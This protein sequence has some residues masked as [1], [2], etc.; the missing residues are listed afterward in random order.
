[1]QY[2]RLEFVLYAAIADAPAACAPYSGIE[3]GRVPSP[4]GVRAP[5]LTSRAILLMPMARPSLC[6]P[7][8]PENARGFIYCS[9]RIILSGLSSLFRSTWPYLGAGLSG[10]GLLYELC[11]CRWADVPASCAT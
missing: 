2:V 8:C 4:M 1:M 5:L 3:G 7:R 10:S 9:W 11:M 6:P